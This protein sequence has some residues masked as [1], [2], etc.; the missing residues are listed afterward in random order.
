MINSKYTVKSQ[1]AFEVLSATFFLLI[2][3]CD[4]FL[5]SKYLNFTFLAYLVILIIIFIFSSIFKGTN[6]ELS[7][8]VLSKVNEKSINFIFSSMFIISIVATTPDISEIF[9]SI[10]ILGV[11]LMSILLSFTIFRFILFTYYDRKGIFD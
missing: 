4:V 2:S 7:N 6:D 9:K 5:N 10:E 8:K 3:I 11:I 1:L